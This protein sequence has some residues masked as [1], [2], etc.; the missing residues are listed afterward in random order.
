MKTL[1][2]INLE[3]I[4]TSVTVAIISF[5]LLVAIISAN[6]TKKDII[7]MKIDMENTRIEYAEEELDERR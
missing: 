5:I 2:Q 6:R 7:K 1:E 3:Y 4:I